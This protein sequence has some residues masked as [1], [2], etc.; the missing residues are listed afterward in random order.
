[1][2]VAVGRLIV[3]KNFRAA[4]VFGIQFGLNLLW[5]PLFF[6]MHE[7]GAAMVVI[8]AMWLGIAA[9]ILLA[10]RMDRVAAGL[11]VPYLIW[12]SYATYLN[13]GFYWLNR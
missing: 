7:I 3:G 12:T 13:G 1:M 9:T 8:L 10:W 6:G 2:G 4:V 11:L 5:T